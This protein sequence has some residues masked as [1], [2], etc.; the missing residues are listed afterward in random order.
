MYIYYYK[1]IM[2]FSDIKTLF[3]PLY[4]RFG[5]D[6]AEINLKDIYTT[7]Y[8]EQD[9]IIAHLKEDI[10]EKY[11]SAQ[12]SFP[13]AKGEDKAELQMLNFISMLA[14]D[15]FMKML[16]MENII[17]HIQEEKGETPKKKRK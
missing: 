2:S 12:K 4:K 9:A 10:E 3:E 7:I 6:D 14:Y 17:D 16:L 8:D 5:K 13:E 1:N 15:V 11:K